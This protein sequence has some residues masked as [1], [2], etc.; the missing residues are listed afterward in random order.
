VWLDFTN[1][2]TMNFW[3]EQLQ[4][5]HNE[6]QFDALWLDMNEPYNF[7]SLKD[8]N[9]DMNDTLMNIPYTPG[10]DPLS[11]STI[12]MYAK[13]T[14][15]SHF[16]LHT[17]YSF[18]ESKATVDALRSIH[19]QKR[20]FVVSRSTAAGQGRYTS[21]WNGDITSEWSSMRNTITNM[22][23]FNIIGMPLIGADICGFMR[24]TTVDLCLR[25]HQLGAF[26]SFS[27][28]HN[29][30]DTIDQDPV[31]MGPKVTAAAKKSLEY[32]YALL[33]YLYTLFYKAHLYGRTV[34]RPLFYEFTNDT[35]LYKMN[36]QFMWG[37]AVM[38]NPALY[39]GRDTVST[40]FP[41]GQWFSNFNKEYFGPIT[42]TIKTEI[43][44]PNI[45]FRA[46]YIVPMQ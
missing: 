21:H 24:N 34:V 7:R 42:V 35:K 12:C 6:I 28:N 30:Y 2:E 40:Y 4:Q 45:N 8:M 44:V 33:P 17:L 15:G 32:R 14:L 1:P 26:Y 19:K 9:C 43:D 25:W 10:Y 23:T 31:A 20:P 13:H 5:F 36:E 39:E 18:Y 37:S 11:S 16:D 22:L 41:K 27:R 38:F 29:D 3:K 46:G